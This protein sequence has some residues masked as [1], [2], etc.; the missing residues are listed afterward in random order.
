MRRKQ[1]NRSRIR[2]IGWLNGALRAVV[3]GIAMWRFSTSFT[4]PTPAIAPYGEA[5]RAERAWTGLVV[6]KGQRPM[7]ACETKGIG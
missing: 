7:A 1:S 4:M 2:E 6:R 3:A 5:V